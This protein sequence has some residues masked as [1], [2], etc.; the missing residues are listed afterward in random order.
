MGS[1]SAGREPTPGSTAQAPSRD[2]RAAEPLGDRPAAVR[3]PSVNLWTESDHAQRYLDRRTSYPHRQEGYG[4]VLELITPAPHRVL[5]LGC[6]DGEVI[7]RIVE[8]APG[9][10]GIACDFSPEMLERA[11]ARFDGSG[12]QVVEHD[13]EVPI[14]DDWGTFDVIASAFAIHHLVDERKQQLYREVFDRLDPGGIFLNLEHVDSPT[15]ELHEAFLVAI[16]TAIEFDDP[17]NKLV[18]VETQLGWLRDIGFEQVDCLWKWREMALLTGIR[19]SG[20]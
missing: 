11:R 9:S 16:G 3:S 19:A 1:L 17:S 2:H 7:G 15:P 10:G 20:A 5:D 4:V 13:L 6:G 14:P 18:S 12:V 8:H